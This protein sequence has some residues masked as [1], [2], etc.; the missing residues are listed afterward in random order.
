MTKLEEDDPADI[1]DMKWDGSTGMLEI[2]PKYEGEAR[3]I[4][5]SEDA[6]EKKVI[7]VKVRPEGK[8]EIPGW[9][10]TNSSSYYLIQNNNMVVKRKGVGTWIVNSARLMVGE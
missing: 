2:Y 4:A 10:S 5:I 7:H 8:L 6:K 3:V 1:M 9:Y